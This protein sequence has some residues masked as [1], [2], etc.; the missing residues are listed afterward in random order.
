MTAIM[1]KPGEFAHDLPEVPGEPPG[2]KAMVALLPKDAE[3]L[4]VIGGD[5]ASGLHVTVSFLGA[6]SAYDDGRQEDM[7]TAIAHAAE[8]GRPIQAKVAGIVLIGSNDE[9]KPATA[10]LLEGDGFDKVYTAVQGAVVEAGGRD[11]GDHPTYLPHLTLGY[12]LDPASPDIL[13]KRGTIIVLDRLCAKFGETLVEFPVGK[14][15]IEEPEPEAEEEEPEAEPEDEEVPEELV[16]ALALVRPLTDEEVRGVFETSSRTMPSLERSPGSSDNWV[17]AAGGLPGYI[18]RIAKHLHYERGM[19]IGHAI[20]TAVNQ[21]KK[22]AAGTGNVKPDTRAKAATAVAQWER[23]KATTKARKATGLAAAGS[24]FDVEADGAW[25]GI[26]AV[27]GVPTGDNRQ[28]SEG[29]LTWRQLPLPLMVM[30]RNP[31][32]GVGHAAA[33][34]CGRIDW[35]ERRTGDGERSELWGGGV[36]DLG[37]TSGK[38]AFRLMDEK[39]LRGVSVDLDD[40]QVEQ[41]NAPASD[42]EAM[43]FDPGMTFVSKGRIIGST[44]CPH[45]ALSEATIQLGADV[46]RAVQ[47]V[48]EDGAV[49]TPASTFSDEEALVAAAGSPQVGTQARAWIPLDVEQGA[50]VAS[51][52]RLAPYPVHPPAA[53]FAKPKLAGP[54]P[55]RVSADGR[56]SGHVASFD[57][58]H[59][60]YQ[61][62]CVPVPR[63]DGSYGKFRNKE[64][65]TAE[66]SM[67]RTGPLVMDTV[68]PDLRRAAS[69]AMAWYHDTGCA[70]ADVALYD[71][72]FGIVAAGAI[73]P[74]VD[75]AQVRSLRGSD[76]SPDWRPVRGPRGRSSLELVALLAVNTSGFITEALVAA[77]GPGWVRPGTT[78]I[79]VDVDEGAIHALVASGGV[80]DD[81]SAALSHLHAVVAALTAEVA[82]LRAHVRPIRAERARAKGMS[83]GA[84]VRQSRMEM[85]LARINGTFVFETPPVVTGDAPVA[86]VDGVQVEEGEPHPFVADSVD[87]TL[88]EVCGEQAFHALHSGHEPAPLGED[89]VLLDDEA[90]LASGGRLP[91]GKR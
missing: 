7:A 75:E 49:A 38:E 6:A 83:L 57:S 30:F 39:F 2:P 50:L 65:L 33:E 20:A 3:S 77:A 26:L 78:R 73:R 63:G 53:W 71:D 14:G 32:G 1:A 59:I 4:A 89:E 22:W 70:V 19:S 24:A 13:A 5:P 35:I 80:T 42:F 87:P 29:A 27:E 52:G 37:S 56:V 46:S 48:D 8:S 88:C 18:E 81:G 67:V 72:E 36:L 54:T 43:D 69:D 51:G 91:F 62:R 34:L 45:P 58:C 21:A 23:M 76:V 41:E 55:L 9:G 12:G 11:V 15:V 47:P 86:V 60:G 90:L 31:D 61:D 25:H 17:E 64:T 10:L 40:L 44:L 68:H 84:G 74:G 16:E 28:I 82:E 66:G 79:L 85:A